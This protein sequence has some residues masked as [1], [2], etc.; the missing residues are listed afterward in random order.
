MLMGLR[1]TSP[2]SQPCFVS[3]WVPAEQ[4]SLAT[5]LAPKPPASRGRTKRAWLDACVGPLGAAKGPSVALMALS[6]EQ[7]GWRVAGQRGQA[8]RPQMEQRPSQDPSLRSRWCPAPSRAGL[9]CS[10]ASRCLPGQVGASSQLLEIT[11]PPLFHQ[12]QPQ[13]S[14]LLFV[15]LPNALQ[16]MYTHIKTQ[17][18]INYLPGKA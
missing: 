16:H 18:S 17:T 3:R 4:T 13:H 14:R 9:I 15:F 7:L 2:K 11:P 12:Y 6:K 8:S 10:S 5:G 1:T